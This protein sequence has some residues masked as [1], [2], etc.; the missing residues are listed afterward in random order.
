MTS[1]LLDLLGLVEVPLTPHLG[2]DQQVLA[3]RLVYR[4]A[5]D[6]TD[7]REPGPQIAPRLAYQRPRRTKGRG[8]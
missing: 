4:H 7:R 3:A 8:A 2:A 1:T 6:D 5:S